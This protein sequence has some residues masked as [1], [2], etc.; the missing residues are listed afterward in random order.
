M[1]YATVTLGLCWDHEKWY[2]GGESGRLAD[3]A[4]DEFANNIE[5][6]RSDLIEGDREAGA[7]WENFCAAVDAAC[8]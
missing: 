6:W 4:L 3:V 2:S 7:D 5:D 8:R 1:H